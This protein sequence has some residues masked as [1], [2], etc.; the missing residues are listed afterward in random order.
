M[1]TP[2][3][4][5]GSEIRNF[6]TR[7]LGEKEAGEIMTYI[8]Q[9]INKEVSTKVDATSKEITLWREELRKTFATKED[10]EKLQQKLV[11]RVSRA[12]STL[13]LWAFVFWT[14]QLIAVL[15]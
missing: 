3:E 12:E 4:V 11:K 10:A 14:T 1:D 7:R 2:L 6:L 15:C 13:I 5:S 9:E 8:N